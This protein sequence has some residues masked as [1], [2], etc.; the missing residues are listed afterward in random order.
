VPPWQQPSGQEIESQTQSPSTQRAP[1][2]QA[3]PRPQLQP[4]SATQTSALIPHA[5]QIAPPC[6]QSLAVIAS[7]Q[8]LP[9]QHPWGHESGVQ[10]QAPFW[11]SRPAPQLG[12]Q[13]E[14]PP[15]V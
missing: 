13:L 15:D 11:H 12:T 5:W 4:P 14:G 6:P 1:P 2:W 10:A 7:T 8:A 3:A 9:V